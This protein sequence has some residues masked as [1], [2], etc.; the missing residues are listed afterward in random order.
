MAVVL[1]CGPSGAGKSTWAKRMEDAGW[2]RMSFDIETWRAGVTSLPA[3]TELMARI[4]SDLVERLE[5]LVPQGTDVVIDLPLATRELRD[6]YRAVMRRLGV[7]AETVYLPVDR[8]TALERVR[9]RRDRG[10]DDYRLPDDVALAHVDTFEEPTFDEYPLRIVDGDVEYRHVRPDETADLLA[11]WAAAAENAARPQDSADAVD[12]LLARDPPAVVVAQRDGAIVGTVIA[13]W[14]GWRA[15][16]YRL[17]VH[18]GARGRGI[19]RA[20]L[21]HAEA[22]LI[23]LG[24]TRL[25]AMVLDA[26]ASGAAVWRAAGYRPQG[27]WSRWVKP[28]GDC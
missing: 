23:A 4:Q 16:L 24:A 3:T 12:A 10:P 26:N 22:R 28:V 14:D 17:A 19:G 2:L 27:E 9:A 7:V 25:D 20:L 8:H 21:R 1:V 5:T 6:D 11:F 18:P 15:H 13:G